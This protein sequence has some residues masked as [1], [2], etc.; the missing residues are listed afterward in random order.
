MRE[1]HETA[2]GR[3]CI[4]V[5][6]KPSE[7]VIRVVPSRRRSNDEALDRARGGH[8]APAF[9]REGAVLLGGGKGSL[10]VLGHGARVTGVRV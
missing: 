3:C 1:I 5:R 2:V 8:V 6:L 9:V 7:T 10:V 4:A